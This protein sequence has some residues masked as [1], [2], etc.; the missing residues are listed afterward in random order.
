LEPSEARDRLTGGI[1]I[2]RDPMDI[3]GCLE[4]A[5]EIIPKAEAI[6]KRLAAAVRDGKL[7][8]PRGPQAVT[9][10]VSRGILTAEEVKL[11]E[12]AEQA[13]RTVIDVDSFTPEEFAPSSLNRRG[14]LKHGFELN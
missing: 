7:S 1:F 13:I 6:E 11:L 10:V 3:T 14:R 9:E 5:L 4:H 2:S 12:A 8:L